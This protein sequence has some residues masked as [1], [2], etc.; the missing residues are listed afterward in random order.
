[1]PM[2]RHSERERHSEAHVI[3]SAAK[4]LLSPD[5]DPSVATALSG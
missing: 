5:G 3:L 2:A 4:N 1:M